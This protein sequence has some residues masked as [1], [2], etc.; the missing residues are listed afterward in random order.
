M[1]LI[2]D[3]VHAELSPLFDSFETLDAPMRKI[4]AES[5]TGQTMAGCT[6][7]EV[8][9]ALSS[10]VTAKSSALYPMMPE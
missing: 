10:T 6:S 2:C 5:E 3:L 8:T 1:I 7:K 4:S 9:R